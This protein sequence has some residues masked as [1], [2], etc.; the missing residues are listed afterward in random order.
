MAP[1]KKCV[2]DAPDDDYRGASQDVSRTSTRQSLRLVELS[3]KRADVFNRPMPKL[4]IKMLPF[5]REARRR[6]AEHGNLSESW[7]LRFPAELRNAI[8]EFVHEDS[9]LDVKH[10]RWASSNPVTW[11]LGRGLTQTCRM[12]RY[13]NLALFQKSRLVSVPFDHAQTYINTWLERANG[14]VASGT[15]IKLDQTPKRP[16]GQSDEDVK[17]EKPKQEFTLDITP[18]LHFRRDNP[19][20][21]FF[22]QNFVDPAKPEGADVPGF[23]RMRTAATSRPNSTR[24][25]S[26]FL[27]FKIAGR[28]ILLEYGCFAIGEAG[29]RKEAGWASCSCDGAESGGGQERGEGGKAHVDGW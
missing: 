27:S 24:S 9:E 13:E 6:V 7:L 2:R 20:F 23:P 29:N 12:L 16:D 19:E 1:S 25:R 4:K 15:V 28:L 18:L 14:K 22:V 11:R 3:A 21:S 8:Y 10:H 5:E 26:S 17:L